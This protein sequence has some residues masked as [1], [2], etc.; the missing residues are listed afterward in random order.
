MCMGVLATVFVHH[1]EPAHKVV[2]GWGGGSEEARV[3]PDE[4]VLMMRMVVVRLRLVV[5]VV[6][7]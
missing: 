4:G 6:A 2:R 1:A 3:R 5:V 7:T